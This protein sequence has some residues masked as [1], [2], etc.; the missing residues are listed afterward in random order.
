MM[1]RERREEE[2]GPC[3][4]PGTE[5]KERKR[6]R[7]T[8]RALRQPRL[9]YADCPEQLDFNADINPLPLNF[10]LGEE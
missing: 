3:A 7:A 2:E 10:I 8:E 6:S 5:E 9:T 4:L 1:T